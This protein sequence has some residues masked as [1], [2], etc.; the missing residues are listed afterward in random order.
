M[1]REMAISRLLQEKAEQV[2]TAAGLIA[3]KTKDWQMIKQ[4]INNLVEEIKLTPVQHEKLKRYQY[5]YNQ[6]VSGRYTEQEIINQV[7]NL[8]K[9]QIVQAYEDVNSTRE[10]WLTTLNINKRFELKMELESAKD[11]KRK[12]IEI[13][14]FKNAAS[15]SK[16]IALLLREIEDEAENPADLFEGIF[17]EASFNPELLGAPKI[18]KKDMVDLMK[19]INAKRNK[20][21][22]LDF[23]ED[24]EFE[25]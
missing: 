5:I 3:Q 15:Y 16:I 6:L 22:N 23:I 11:C 7:M 25:E 24:L 20:K 13:G 18:Y 10:I 19:S 8:Y 9:V 21:L 1:G 14:D 2:S 4:Y 12:C 17:I